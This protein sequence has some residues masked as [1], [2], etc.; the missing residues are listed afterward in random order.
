MHQIE[1]NPPVGLHTLTIVDENGE[2]IV[3]TF[4]IIGK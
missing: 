4:E 2:K 3:R 1:L